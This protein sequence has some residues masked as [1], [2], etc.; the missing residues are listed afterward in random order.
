MIDIE[1][2][3]PLASELRKIRAT[4]DERLKF[5]SNR[6]LRAMKNYQKLR[7]GNWHQ[8]EQMCADIGKYIM[9]CLAIVVERQWE[10]E[11]TA[12][13]IPINS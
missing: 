2:F 5:V 11:R 9:T 8:R 13:I 4:T 10:S 7:D 12:K 6:M 3:K 1:D